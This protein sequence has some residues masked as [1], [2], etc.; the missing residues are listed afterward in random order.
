MAFIGPMVTAAIPSRQWVAGAVA[1]IA[2]RRFE[3]RDG[4]R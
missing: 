3:R 4:R 2:A 1:D